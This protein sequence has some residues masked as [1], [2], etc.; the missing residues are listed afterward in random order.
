MNTRWMPI[1]LVVVTLCALVSG[2]LPFMWRSPLVGAGP[3]REET[4]SFT[5]LRGVELATIGELTI[6]LGDREEL[7]ISAAQR[8][9]DNLDVRVK[10]GVLRI[11]MRPNVNLRNPG[12]VRYALTV[13]A[14]D[15]IVLSSVGGATAPD[16][17]SQHLALLL[18]ST[19]SL[20]TGRLDCTTAEIRVSST[21]SVEVASLHADRLEATLGSTGRVAINGGKVREQDV[22]LRST[23]D[24]EARNLASQTARMRLTSVGS[25]TIR[26]SDYLDA[27][28]T[29]VG[30]LRYIGLP[31]ISLMATSTGRITQ[32]REQ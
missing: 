21:G 25:A 22:A 5:G 17:T 7:R 20:R 19:G 14:L 15:T 13:K 29:S 8:V 32:L 27:T 6:A 26:V 9:L 31:R 2:C 23:G 1:L 12:S 4:R 16:L 18:Y 11:G 10:D 24:Y 28:L 3:A 30:H